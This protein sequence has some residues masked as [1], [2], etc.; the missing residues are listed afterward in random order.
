M[1]GERITHLLMAGLL[2]ASGIA[3]RESDA[4]WDCRQ[5]EASGTWACTGAPAP[6]EPTG[7]DTAPL[8]PSSADVPVLR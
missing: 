6:S 2:L 5:E 3:A 8:P 7:L 1:P 4:G